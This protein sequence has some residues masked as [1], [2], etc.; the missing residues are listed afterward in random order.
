MEHADR[1]AKKMLL[2]QAATATGKWT[3]NGTLNNG[4]ELMRDVEHY[5]VLDAEGTT[6]VKTV[7]VKAKVQR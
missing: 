2:L 4:T 7:F 1:A 5:T 3:R 6:K